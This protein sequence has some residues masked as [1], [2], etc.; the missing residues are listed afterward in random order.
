MVCGIMTAKELAIVKTCLSETDTIKELLDRNPYLLHT[1]IELRLM[2]VGCAAEA[3]HTL[4]DAAR[5][6]GIKLDQLVARLQAAVDDAV[7][8]GEKES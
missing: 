3:F 2:C 5:G 1:F 4:A 8:T 6:N 7:A